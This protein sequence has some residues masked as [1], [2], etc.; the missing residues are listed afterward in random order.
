[1]KKK[2]KASDKNS[3]ISMELMPA[4]IFFSQ[5]IKEFT[6]TKYENNKQLL[7]TFSPY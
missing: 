4:K 3:D 6:I 1:M 7:L 5:I 2:K